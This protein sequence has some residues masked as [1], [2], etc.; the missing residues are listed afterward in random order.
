MLIFQSE[1]VSNCQCCEHEQA[2]CAT[3]SKERTPAMPLFLLPKI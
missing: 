1:E 3:G 2:L